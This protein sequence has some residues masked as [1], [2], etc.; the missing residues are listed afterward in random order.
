MQEII[1]DKKQKQQDNDSIRLDVP[2]S[3]KP[4]IKKKFAVKII[5]PEETY[6][7]L[8]KKHYAHRLPPIS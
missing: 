3:Q 7:W 6:D 1:K 8:I 2:V 5:K 4:T